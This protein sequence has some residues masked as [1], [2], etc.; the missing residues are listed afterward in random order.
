MQF[1]EFHDRIALVTGAGSGI[2]AAVARALAANGATVAALDRDAER[3]RATVEKIRSDDHRA[4]A[5]EVDVSDRARV[6][7]VVDRVETELGPIS[8]LVNSHGVLHV[9]EVTALAD[10][11]WTE[12]LEVNATGVFLVTRAVVGR[13]TSRAAGAVV[14]IASNVV[15]TARSGM[16]AYSASKAAVSAFTRC[17]ALEVA[18]HGIRCNLVAPGSTDTP[19]LRALWPDGDAVSASIAGRPEAYRVGIPLGKVAQP[20]EVA[21]AVLYLLSDRA[22]HITMQQ[23]TVDGGATLGV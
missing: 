18:P 4:T 10:E 11:Q 23:L 20:G 21:D 2:G 1:R 3:L 9:G 19:M 8:Y 15:G 22:S 14:N 16:S 13:M 17:L 12:C 5:Y 7:R 6:E